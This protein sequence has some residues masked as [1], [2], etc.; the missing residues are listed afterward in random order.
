M[1]HQPVQ[2]WSFTTLDRQRLLLFISVRVTVG[3]FVEG[4]ERATCR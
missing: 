3:S 2:L 1:D 4:S